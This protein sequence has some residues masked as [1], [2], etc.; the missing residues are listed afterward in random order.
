MCKYRYLIN[1]KEE[2]IYLRSRHNTIKVAIQNGLDIIPS[3]TFGNTR[4]F[5]I[6]VGA[7]SES[8]SGSG[9]SS[10]IA[11]LSRKLR[12]SIIFFYGKFFLTI[13]YQIPLRIVRGRMIKV[14][15]EAE[16]SPEKVQAVLDQLIEEVQRLYNEQK[17][18]W[19]TRPLVIY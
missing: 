12:M 10:M 8:D 1:D 17:P 7:K 19:E 18:E 15:Q 4:L 14:Q 5:D 9:I 13:P 11:R 3:Y 6:A 16:P 2:G